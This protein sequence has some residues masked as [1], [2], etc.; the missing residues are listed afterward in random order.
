MQIGIHPG[1]EHRDAT[2]LLELRGHRIVVKS[3]RNQ[4]VETSIPSLA[5][6]KHQIGSLDRS[7]LRSN[8]D[9]G[10]T[11]GVLLSIYP[12][13]TYHLAWPRDQGDEVDPVLFA[14][15]LDSSR[16]EIL[17]DHLGKRLRLAPIL[18]DLRRIDKLVVFVD[19]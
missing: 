13:C 14:C 16:S 15:L 1:L 3:T 9:R 10:A 12:L 6:R 8:H 17:K 2:K 18:L 5:R 11:I 19:P 7:K 4:N